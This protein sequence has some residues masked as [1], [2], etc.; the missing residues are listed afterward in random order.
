MKSVLLEVKDKVP[1]WT[2]LFAD[3]MASIGVAPR[4]CKA[5]T[6]Q[7][8]GKV[9]RTVGFVKKSF[10]AG[11]CFTEIDDLPSPPRKRGA[12]ASIHRGIRPPTNAPQSAENGN[13]VPRCLNL[14]P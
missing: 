9:E 13:R 11:V 1:Y 2:P 12:S 7:T 4:V 3:F 6:P 10:W 5:Y 8:K 14:L